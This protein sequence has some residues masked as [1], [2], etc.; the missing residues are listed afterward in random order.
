MIGHRVL[1]L[2]LMA[3]ITVARQPLELPD[4]CVLVAGLAFQ[5]SM[6]ADQGEAVLVLLDGR[7]GYVPSLHGVTL[8]ASGTKL[9]AVKIGVT[10]FATHSHVAEHQAGMALLATHVGVH[11]TQRVL[12]FVVIELRD[13]ADGPP[14]SEAVTVLAWHVEVPVRTLDLRARDGLRLL[15]QGHRQQ[16]SQQREKQRYQ[17]RHEFGLTFRIQS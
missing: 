1:I 5:R 10:I 15:A 14:R 6:C 12:G 9:S 2:G 3:R 16:H 7:H 13:I 8:F 17:W 4:G 11:A